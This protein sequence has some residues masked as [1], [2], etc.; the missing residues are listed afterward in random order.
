MPI[1]KPPIKYMFSECSAVAKY[2]VDYDAISRDKSQHI[3][4]KIILKAF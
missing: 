2:H 3:P 1:V 4:H